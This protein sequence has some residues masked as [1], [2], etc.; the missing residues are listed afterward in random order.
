[1]SRFRLCLY[2]VVE[3]PG[4]SE[5]MIPDPVDDCSGS[6][7]SLSTSL[8]PSSSAPTDDTTSSFNLTAGV[9]TGIFTIVVV[10]VVMIVMVTVLVIRKRK[11]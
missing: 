3:F 10:T 5:G 7:C 6:D 2:F 4:D 8:P 11:K 9:V 1:M